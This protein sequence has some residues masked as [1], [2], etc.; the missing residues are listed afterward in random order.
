MVSVKSH[1]F[2]Q[3]ARMLA[4]KYDAINNLAINTT[5]YCN[6]VEVHGIYYPKSSI[7]IRVKFVWPQVIL[8]FELPRI[9]LSPT[10]ELLKC[11]VNINV[12]FMAIKYLSIHDK[13]LI[14]SLFL[15]H[16]IVDD[17]QASPITKQK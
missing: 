12:R 15:I 14:T 13:I 8:L 17:W 6:S 2:P 4:K 10:L 7:Y 11:K 9:Y 5:V 16:L 3:F 1:L